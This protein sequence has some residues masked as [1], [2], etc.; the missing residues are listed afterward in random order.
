MMRRISLSLFCLGLGGAV[1]SG[2]GG[3][4]GLPDATIENT[5]DTVRL[6]ALNGTDIGTPSALDLLGGIPV[7]PELAD[8]F[9]LGFDVE[10]DGVAVLIPS[11]LL[12]GSATAGTL[13]MSESF[14]D[15][16]RAPLEEY[17]TDSMRVVTEGTV[18]VGRSRSS[19]IGCPITVGSLPRY[20][21][22]EILEIDGAARTVTLRLMANLNC[23]Y[24]DLVEGIPVD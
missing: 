22:I 15:V 24:R 2:C 23:G 21:K 6:W 12:G 11:G 19:S 20:A 4:I 14:D 10:P 7:R 8:V 9:D 3:D 17:V 16:T 13:L 18:L 1:A 5:V